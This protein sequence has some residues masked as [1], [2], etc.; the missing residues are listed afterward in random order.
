MTTLEEKKKEREQNFLILLNNI[1]EFLEQNPDHYGAVPKNQE[2]IGRKLY[3]LA[4]IRKGKRKSLSY[5]ETHFS[6]LDKIIPEWDQYTPSRLNFSRLCYEIELFTQAKNAFYD[7]YDIPKP[8]RDL[9]VPQAY[10][11]GEYPLGRKLFRIKG[12]FTALTDEQKQIITN[13]NPVC[14]ER[15]TKFDTARFY[16]ELRN[17]VN[18]KNKEYDILNIPQDIRDYS[19]D[20]ETVVGD[21][22]IG[23]KLKYL[24]SN[25]KKLSD[26]EKQCFLDLVPSLFEKRNNNSFSFD[27]FFIEYA[28]FIKQKNKY[29]DKIN[30]PAEL[31]TYSIS[32][33]EIFNEYPLGEKLYYIRKHYSLKLNQIQ[34]LNKLNPKWREKPVAFDFGEFYG[35]YLQFRK[36]RD[37]Y[38]NKRNVP[39][40][41]R[42]YTVFSTSYTNSYPLG[43]NLYL[44]KTGKIKLSSLQK[45]Y[46]LK[47]DPKILKSAINA[48]TKNQC[49]KAEYERMM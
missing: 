21:Y 34:A 26:E 33:N 45:D 42:A 32:R 37:E 36:Q 11:N 17:F 25:W 30:T 48:P 44:I 31:R 43:C 14:F 1:K 12:G 20:Y 8:L 19:F 10:K 5:N 39:Q 46:L 4:Q 18:E 3:T 7:K 49:L 13:I 6:V 16:F 9:H 47:I 24:R 40:E 38:Y 28:S 29:Y 22:K 27:R 41:N 35:Q 23:L 2:I 15:F